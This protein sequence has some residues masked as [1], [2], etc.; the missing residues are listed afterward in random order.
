MFAA[1]SLH[2]FDLRRSGWFP[3]PFFCAKMGVSSQTRPLKRLSSSQN[4]H[5]KT[6]ALITP[7]SHDG[8]KSFKFLK[9]WKEKSCTFISRA[10]LMNNLMSLKI[11]FY[12]RF[13]RLPNFLLT[14][15]FTSIMKKTITT[16]IIA[17]PAAVTHQ[18]T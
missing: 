10:Q 14:N 4:H 16:D 11:I 9:Y 7:M 12:Y 1:F 3:A 15:L 5:H 18:G 17:M 6:L 13:L 2:W 8:S